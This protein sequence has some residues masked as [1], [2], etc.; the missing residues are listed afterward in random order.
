MAINEVYKVSTPN[1]LPTL[2]KTL[3]SIHEQATGI[4]YV[5]AIPT[6][7]GTGKIVIMDDGAGDM[8]LYVRTGKGNIAYVALT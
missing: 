5:S 8:R 3:S 1:D 4:E 6:K 2:Q 7:V